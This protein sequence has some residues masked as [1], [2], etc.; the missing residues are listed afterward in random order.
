MNVDDLKNVDQWICW[1]NRNGRKTPVGARGG[2]GSSTD[3]KTWGSYEEA[4]AYAEANNLTGVGFVF[5]K[6]D[7]FCGVDLDDCITDGTVS[8]EALEIINELNSYTEISPS[9]TG[10]KIYG[11]CHDILMGRNSENLEA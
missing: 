3:P 11:R 6:D 8:D 7:A 10:V 4:T 9:G 2:V 5:T 1:D